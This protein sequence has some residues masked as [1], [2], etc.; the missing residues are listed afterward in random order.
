MYSRVADR[1]VNFGASVIADKALAAGVEEWFGV[2]WLCPGLENLLMIDDNG[3]VRGGKI[4][5]FL[6]LVAGSFFL[7]GL[8]FVDGFEFKASDLMYLDTEDT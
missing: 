8:V 6:F 5:A 4:I 1:D 7:R 3:T 2:L